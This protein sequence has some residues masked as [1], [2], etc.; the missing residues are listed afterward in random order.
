M[1]FHSVTYRQYYAL[2][3]YL[4]SQKVTNKN[5]SYTKQYTIGR[6]KHRCSISRNTNSTSEEQLGIQTVQ[7]RSTLKKIQVRQT[8]SSENSQEYKLLVVVI[9]RNTN[10]QQQES[11]GI[12]TVHSGNI[13]ECEYSGIRKE[14]RGIRG[15]CCVLFIHVCAHKFFY[16]FP[17]R[18]SFRI[19]LGLSTKNNPKKHM[20]KEDETKEV[21]KEEFSLCNT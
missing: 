9:V 21:E 4:V 7:I 19:F 6:K 14:Y 1:V 11:L 5:P 20:G 17:L 12:Q 10:S 3:E 13:Q 8:V 2:Q 15:N 18:V 16:D